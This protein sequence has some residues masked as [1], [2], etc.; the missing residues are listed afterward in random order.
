MDSRCT[1]PVEI[2]M[3]GLRGSLP[4]DVL[5]LVQDAVHEW[6]TSGKA[7]KLLARDPSLWTGR[8]EGR[9][10]GWLTIVGDQLAEGQRLEDIKEDVRARGF[11]HAVLLGMGGSSLCAEVLRRTFTR[12]DGYPEIHV[13]DSTVPARIKSVE[14]SVD[15]SN[16][17]FIVSSKSGTTLEPGIMKEYFYERVRS[18]VGQDRAGSF[19]FA[20]TDPGSKLE[21]EAKNDGFL[22][23]FYGVPEI[24][25]RYSALSNFGMVPAAVMGLDLMRYLELTAGMTAACGQD[26]PVEDNPGIV[27]GL[28]LGFLCTA[29]RDKITI[30]TS[31]GIAAL[32]TWLEQLIAESTGKESKALIPVDL[33]EIGPPDIYGD[34]RVFVYLRLGTAPAASQDAAMDTITASG[35]PV[36]RIR[37]D[38]PYHI[39]QEFFRW[40]V[41]TAVAGSVLGINPFDQ[42]DVEA[43]KIAT[44]ELTAEYEETGSLPSESPV[45][46]EK[47]VKLFTDDI[48]AAELAAAAGE[49]RTL[50][51]YLHAH[52]AR[53]GPD[54][55]FALLG[56]VNSD[57]VNLERLQAI[58]H[59][60][61][62]RKKVATSLGFGPRFLH[63]TGQAYKGGPNTGVFLQVTSDDDGDIS[64]PGRKY[65]F[66]TVKT[67]QQRGDFQ[68]LTDRGRRALR[69][70][71]GAD[72][73]AGLDTLLDA[74]KR[75]V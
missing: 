61:R 21:K 4:K 11:S 7:R 13:L 36:I 69:V 1:N 50:A 41:A 63:S 42:P 22:H 45:L 20:I 73:R 75:S 68:V 52:L 26:V 23:I 30:V 48:N 9:W 10:L 49:D 58:R 3:G 46:E 25:G 32:G 64:V 62:D 31:P 29:G 40:E 54:D 17:L 12:A 71:L 14:N 70:H 59:I 38:D 74:V 18:V 44:R 19:F 43:S 2:K 66:G 24:G 51:G 39:G 56:F 33:E 55:Y 60:V 5:V 53:I 72:V 8:D 65:T 57:D 34:D 16:T 28:V 37:V 27:L 15:Q 6:K 47:G 35:I 67:A